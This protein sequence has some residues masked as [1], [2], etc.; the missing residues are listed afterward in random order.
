M[1]L[2]SLSYSYLTNNC[3]FIYIFF[4][5]FSIFGEYILLNAEGLRVKLKNLFPEQESHNSFSTLHQEKQL[6]RQ[7]HFVK[8]FYS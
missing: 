2:P 3:L 1:Y 4:F 8:D 5:F 7:F 6:P